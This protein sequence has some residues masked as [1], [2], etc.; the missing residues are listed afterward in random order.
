MIAQLTRKDA[1]VCRFLALIDLTRLA[2]LTQLLVDLISRRYS[3]LSV[4]ELSN[5]LIV[6]KSETWRTVTGEGRT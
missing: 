5:S 6:N 3:H 1:R 2:M 4:V